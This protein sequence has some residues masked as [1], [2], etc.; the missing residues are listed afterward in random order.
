MAVNETEKRALGFVLASLLAG[1]VLI[2]A[3]RFLL[4]RK[5]LSP[6]QFPR[7]E[8]TRVK[9]VNLNTATVPELEL[10]PGIGPVTAGR[11][12]ADREAR[13]GF[14]SVDDLLEIK[15][16]SKQKLDAIRGFV[17]LGPDSLQGK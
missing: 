2:F 15:G 14:S 7:T 16:I 12:V 4:H 6:E 17:E 8:E 9:K 10:L 3:G 13:G 5:P 1:I 11:I